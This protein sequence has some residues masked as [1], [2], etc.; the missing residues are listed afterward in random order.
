M[1]KL[2][3][4]QA[5]RAFQASSEVFYNEKYYH[6]VDDVSEASTDPTY[7]NPERPR[8]AKDYARYEHV[9]PSSR[10]IN[11]QKHLQAIQAEKN[12]ALA[13]LDTEPEDKIAI[14]YDTTTRRRNAGD[15][16]SLIMKISN[17]LTYRLRPLSLAVE[18]RKTIS[19]LLVE[20][21]Q[22]LA[23]AGNTSAKVL[24]EKVTSVMTD[25]VSKNLHVEDQVA[26]TLNS[27]HIPFHLLCVSHTCEVFDTG[28]IKVLLEAEKKLG[29][30]ETLITRMPALQSFLPS[31][32][33]VTVAS[34]EALNKLVIN[35]GHKSSQWQ[36]FD[37]HLAETGKTKKH[38]Q[39]HERRFGKLGYT[40]ST[41]LYHLEDYEAVLQST[42][43]N[44]QLVQACRIYVEYDFVL[45]GLKALSWFTYKV[46]LPFLNMFEQ[47]TQKDLV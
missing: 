39:F 31:S 9:L 30:R 43:S 19:D 1:P 5:R 3:V 32:K 16:T 38:N 10:V 13:I 35:N 25:S 6:S 36:L 18:N 23:Q 42:K 24:W 14:H 7:K 34:L 21:F 46:T 41:I 27:T 22:H 29:L 33:S 47:I 17:S 11:T 28:N 45:K 12:C 4:E 15:W 2:E 8:S 26:A 37:K 44:N 40:A 20:E